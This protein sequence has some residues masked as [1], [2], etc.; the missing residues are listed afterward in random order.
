MCHFMYEQSKYFGEK[1][2]VQRPRNV[3][4]SGVVLC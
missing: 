3:G 4:E 1:K 2:Y